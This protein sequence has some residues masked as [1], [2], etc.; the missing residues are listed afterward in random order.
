MRL[1]KSDGRARR[2]AT[3]GRRSPREAHVARDAAREAGTHEYEVEAMLL[4]TFRTH[5]C[6]APGVRPHRRLGRERDDP[7]LPQ[8]NR[9]WRTASC[10]SIDAGCEYDYYARDVTRTF[11]VGGK[12]SKP[13]Q[14]DL[15]ARARRRRTRRSRRP[16]R[17]RRSSRSTRRCVDVHHRRPRR[18]SAS[19][20]GER[21]AAHQGRGATS[22]S[23]CTRPATGSA[24]TCTTSA[25]T[26]VGGKPRPLE[27][28]MVITVE[29]GLY[30]AQDD[31]KV[32]AGVARHRR[33]HRGRH[34]R[35][36]GRQREPH[37]RDPED[38]ER[39]RTCLFLRLLPQSWQGQI[40]I[41][42]LGADP[43]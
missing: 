12:F 15:R 9:R 19:S 6:R 40:T 30:I 39:A 36:P 43:T 22:R 24:W 32:A 20:Q 14:R 31:D 2:D 37:G 3:R 13:Q 7:A 23:S 17:A 8:N 5:G 11:P 26:T 38:G 33:A 35:H 29:P 28:G 41:S 10:S 1:F 27:P 4:E 16:R 42:R 18:S 21:R 34:P 25:P